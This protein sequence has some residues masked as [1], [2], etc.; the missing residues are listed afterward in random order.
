[1]YF[2][3][4]KARL[5]ACLKNNPVR[6]LGYLM[7]CSLLLF[8]VHAKTQNIDSLKKQVQ[9]LKADSNLIKTLLIVSQA[10]SNKNPDSSILY[11]DKAL[12]LAAKCHLPLFMIPAYQYKAYA[13]YIKADYP[14]AL[15]NYREM[16][17]VAEKLHDKKNMAA[18]INNQGN[19]YIELADYPQAINMYKEAMKVAET[20]KDEYGIAR[21][22]NNIGYVYKE[23]G[24]YEHAVEN[25][26][27]ALKV[28]EKLALPKETAMSYNNIAAVYSRQKNLDKA[29]EYNMEALAIQRKNNIQGGMAISL[30][31]IANTYAEQKQYSKA[32]DIYHQALEIYLGM[33]DKRQ[34]A[35]TYSNLGNMYNLAGKLDSSEFYYDKAVALNR[36]IGNS[37]NLAASLIGNA[38]TL[39]NSGNFAKAK[40]LLDSTEALIRSTNRKEEFKQYYQVLSDYHTAAGNPAMGLNFFRKYVTQKD[41][42]LNEQNSKSIADLNIKYETEKKQLQIE[43]LNKNTAIKDLEINKQ[44][45]AL[46]EKAFELARQQLTLTAADLTISNNNLKIENKDELLLTNQLD[47]SRTQQ[48]IQ[49]LNE[50]AKVQQLEIQNQK[51]SNSRKNSLL[52]SILLLILAGT[53]AIVSYYRRH[54]EKEMQRLQAIVVHQQELAAQAV[55]QAEESERK[56]IAMDLHDGVG[57]LMSAAKMNLSALEGDIDFKHPDQIQAF[58][59]VYNL[60]DSSLTEVRSVSHLMMPNALK[61]GLA[62]ALEQFIAQVD[63]RSLTI[64]L[65][66]EGL[67]KSIDATLESVLYRVIQECVSNVIKHAN[68]KTL[69]IS[70]TKSG[71]SIDAT[72]EDDGNGFDYATAETDKG[73]GLRNIKSRIEFLKGEIDW[74]SG[75]GKGT[76]VTF[77]VPAG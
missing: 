68:A 76:L 1:M 55:L 51:L 60:I 54:K 64:Q 7:G 22:Y 18:A 48:H 8:P 3:L 19:V 14:A 59:K 61:S 39:I 17:G 57:Q 74:H 44:N 32:L 9:V 50:A 36:Q 41:S 63:K 27:N 53:V 35:I 56:R 2:L 38:A 4:E 73:I 47:S 49:Q 67:D 70:I 11:S 65:H 28:F 13:Q 23:L 31:G 33:K 16:Y 46:S 71:N 40:D 75:P 58:N 72:L 24:E 34:V 5:F 25:M 21:G 29:L 52:A 37:R 30:Q 45:L 26:L 42:I 62:R 10:Y 43:L 15:S 66:T 12:A 69:D 20:L 6:S 77:R